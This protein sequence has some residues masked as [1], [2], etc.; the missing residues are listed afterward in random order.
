MWFVFQESHFGY[1]T[2]YIFQAS[3]PPIRLK[4]ST[5]NLKQKVTGKTNGAPYEFDDIQ[6]S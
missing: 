4:I 2:I 1:T 6:L 3:G 5:Q